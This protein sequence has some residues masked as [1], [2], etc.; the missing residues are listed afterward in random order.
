MTKPQYLIRTAVP[1]SALTLYDG[2][3]GRI[4]FVNEQYTE[5]EVPMLYFRLPD[6]TIQAISLHAELRAMKAALSS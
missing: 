2:A 4:Y 5:Y 6:G 1:E 3:G